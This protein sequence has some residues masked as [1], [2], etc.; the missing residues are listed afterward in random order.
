MRL[1]RHK[2]PASQIDATVRRANAKVGADF[3]TND[4]TVW[5][6]PDAVTL[7]ERTIEHQATAVPGNRPI[8]KGQ[9]A[10]QLLGSQ[11]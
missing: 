5:P 2:T 11:S 10:V 9:G 3:S 7:Q 6:R 8:T 4:H 1:W